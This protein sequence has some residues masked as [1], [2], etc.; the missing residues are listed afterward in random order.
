MTKKAKMEARLWLPWKYKLG[1][2]TE[3]IRLS[4]DDVYDALNEARKDIFS[5]IS[6][7]RRELSVDERLE[8]EKRMLILEAIEHGLRDMFGQA[9]KDTPKF[10]IPGGKT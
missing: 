9:L 3:E 2:N 4:S 1:V 7:A 5:S 8:K 6:N 10:Q